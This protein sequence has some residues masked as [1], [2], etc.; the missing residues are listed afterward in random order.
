MVFTS[1]V[2]VCRIQDQLEQDFFDPEANLALL[3]SPAQTV[4]TRGVCFFGGSCGRVDQ[5]VFEKQPDPT[6][7]VHNSF[8]HFW[9]RRIS[10]DRE[11]ASLFQGQRS[12]PAS[13][14]AKK[15]VK[16]I[17]DDAIWN[18][19]CILFA[20]RV[21]FFG[22]DRTSAPFTSRAEVRIR[23]RLYL[24]HPE[25]TSIPAIEGILLK[26][27]PVKGQRVLEGLF[28]SRRGCFVEASQA[29]NF[30]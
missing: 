24:L 3:K 6:Q 1:L 15:W 20:H 19:S 7:S 14:T 26:A 22:I 23:A 29:I 28:W 16:S 21:P 11:F 10:A 13:A 18:R 30:L 5:R 12:S 4:S 27:S 2:R 17:V 25:K 9:G 8:H